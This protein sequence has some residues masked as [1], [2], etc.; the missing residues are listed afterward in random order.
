MAGCQALHDRHGV[1]RW[2]HRAL[3]KAPAAAQRIHP[4]LSPTS[5]WTLL[6]VF[7]LGLRVL[8]RHSSVYSDRK[9]S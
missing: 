1:R 7:S 2:L 8:S 4:G 6:L 5:L 9:P 3:S